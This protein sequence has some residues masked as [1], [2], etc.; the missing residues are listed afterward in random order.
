MCLKTTGAADTPVLK[1]DQ[2]KPWIRSALRKWTPDVSSRRQ[3]LRES[4]LAVHMAYS[5]GLFR[6]LQFV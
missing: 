4:S 6:A 1:I 5:G 2:R 3:R